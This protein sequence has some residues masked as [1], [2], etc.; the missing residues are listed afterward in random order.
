MPPTEAKDLIELLSR[1]GLATDDPQAP[2][3]IQSPDPDDDYLTALAS[4]A[5]AV[6]VSGDRNLL[7]LAG[8]IPM[9]SPAEFL[10][11]IEASIEN[12]TWFRAI[13]GAESP[14]SVDVDTW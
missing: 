6:L 9:Y 11:L 1:A 3:D 8:Q 4:I 14:M 12:R 13:S 5:R 7:G 2:P 10:A